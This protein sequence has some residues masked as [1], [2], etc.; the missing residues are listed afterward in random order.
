MKKFPLVFLIIV[1]VAQTV[2]EFVSAEE[3]EYDQFKAFVILDPGHGGKDSGAVSP[4]GILEKNVTLSIA[5]KVARRLSEY[6]VSVLL[7]RTDDRFL[8]LKERNLFIKKH[9]PDLSISIHANSSPYPHVKGFESFMYF[10]QKKTGF[11][12][13][14]VEDLDPGRFLYP[15]SVSG[16]ARENRCMQL[17]YFIHRKT[18][19]LTGANDRGVKSG[20]FYVIKHNQS[21]SLLVETGFLSNR[22]ESEKLAQHEYQEKLAQG[23][24]DGS[25]LAMFGKVNA[26]SVIAV[27]NK[28]KPNDSR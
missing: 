18:I 6:G 2:Q 5:Q 13:C 23:L 7:T 20:N 21:P 3:F 27:P 12:L 17:A 9:R 24:A 16:Q 22:R 11:L 1:L 10:K 15:M 14:S 19:Q 4:S 26:L 8:S 25:M 28:E